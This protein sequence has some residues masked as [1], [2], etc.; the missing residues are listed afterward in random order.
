ML[1]IFSNKDTAYIF[2][3]CIFKKVHIISSDIT[4]TFQNGEVKYSVVYRV[5]ET[6]R[7]FPRSELYHTPAEGIVTIRMLTEFAYREINPAATEF[8]NKNFCAINISRWEPSPNSI[9]TNCNFSGTGLQGVKFWNTA[10]VNCQFIRSSLRAADFRRNTF[11][12]CKFKDS[13]LI[14]SKFQKAN[15]VNCQFLCLNL[16]EASFNKATG[17]T[18]SELL[19]ANNSGERFIGVLGEFQP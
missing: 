13:V 12:N 6:S 8:N 19:L 7:L 15:F 5:A 9:F 17:I 4:K 18:N 10:F 2:S 11:T 1:K 16:H 14:R 3:G